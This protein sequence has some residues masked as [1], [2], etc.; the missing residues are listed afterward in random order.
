MDEGRKGYILISRDLLEDEIW[1]KQPLVLKVWMYLL[2]RAQHTNYKGLKR[3]ELWTS[4]NEL[5]E[6]CTYYRG[7]RPERPSKKQIETALDF[8]RKPHEGTTKGPSIVTTKATRGM[9]V[10]ICNYNLY[11]DPKTYEGHNGGHNE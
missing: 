2:L 9:H 6:A 10:T 4:Y 5:R 7:G 11:Q 1:F 3:G 8:L